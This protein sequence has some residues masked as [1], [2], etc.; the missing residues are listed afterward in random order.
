MWVKN[1]KESEATRFFFPLQAVS[2]ELAVVSLERLRNKKDMDCCSFVASFTVVVDLL[3]GNKQVIHFV[4]GRGIRDC[5]LH[6]SFFGR[7]SLASSN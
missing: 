7:I 6:R 5:P 1:N 3:C 2:E 4:I